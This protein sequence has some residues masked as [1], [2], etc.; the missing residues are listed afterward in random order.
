MPSEPPKPSISVPPRGIALL[1]A[2][3]PAIVWC[4]GYIGSGE[5]ILAT[6]TGAILGTGVLWAVVSGIFLKYLIGLAGGW[7]TVATGESGVARPSPTS[8]TS[9]T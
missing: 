8:A 7:Y 1:F 2:I 5:V 9:R 3:G 4:A 6:R